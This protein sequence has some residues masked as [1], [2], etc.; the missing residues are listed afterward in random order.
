MCSARGRNCPRRPVEC[1]AARERSR[2]R[3]V[4]HLP[5]H[6]V[7]Q[8]LGIA[9]RRSRRT[10][11]APSIAWWNPR[12]LPSDRARGQIGEHV[13]HEGTGDA[14][15]VAASLPVSSVARAVRTRRPRGPGRRP[16]PARPRCP[17]CRPVAAPPRHHRRRHFDAC[18][19]APRSGDRIGH[20]SEDTGGRISPGPGDRRGDQWRQ[21]I[22]VVAGGDPVRSPR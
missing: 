6:E 21:T 13:G 18:R 14:G 19:R 22:G 4:G 2:R 8:E 16:G 15:F 12:L 20:G 7:G 11:P 1:L 9:G 5:R 3:G 10:P 17:W